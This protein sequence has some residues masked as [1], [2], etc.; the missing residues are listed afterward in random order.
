MKPQSYVSIRII[1]SFII[2]LIVLVVFTSL[3]TN[4]LSDEK[5]RVFNLLRI[6]VLELPVA[7]S[8]AVFIV[9]TFMLPDNKISSLF[10]SSPAG[11][12]LPSLLLAIFVLVTIGILQELIMPTLVKQRF[13]T[14]GVKDAVVSFDKRN[15]LVI[16]EAKYDGKS[17]NIVL[18]N[19]YLVDKN[20]FS[21]KGFFA[22]SSYIP[23]TRELVLGKKSYKLEG[24]LEKVLLFYISKENFMSIW[25]FPVVRDSFTVFGIK[26]SPISLILYEKI[27]MPTIGFIFMLFSVTF[28]WMWRIR[29]S[30]LLMP[31]YI[32]VGGVVVA[33]VIKVGF[34]FTIKLFELLVFTF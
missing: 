25:E 21:G 13:S 4:S 22:N 3:V 28:G 16:G 34:Y 7:G 11:L 29:K 30:S 26:S 6:I 14:E 23:G 15:Y 31:L 27:F 8:I 9:Y 24:D 32:V 5:N 33:I 19:L 12:F 2:T 17:K 20:T 10:S 18:R 1:I